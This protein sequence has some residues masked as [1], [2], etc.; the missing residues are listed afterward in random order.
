[1]LIEAMKNC[2]V[3]V[4]VHTLVGIGEKA[5]LDFYFLFSEKLVAAS[6][7]IFLEVAA[8]ATAEAQLPPLMSS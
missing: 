3:D 7:F 2:E 4:T 5:Q 6:H 1:M 8:S